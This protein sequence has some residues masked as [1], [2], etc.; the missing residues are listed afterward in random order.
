MPRTLNSEWKEV[1]GE[2]ADEIHDEYVN[3]LGNLTLIRYNQELG[4]KSFDDKKKIYQ[5]KEGLVISRQMITDQDKWGPDQIVK[6]ENW[7]ASK[8]VQDIIPI[9]DSMKKHSNY[10]SG[11]KRLFSF[12]EAGLVGKTIAFIED[13]KI[14]AKVVSNREVEYEGQNWKLSKLTQELKERNGSIS[15]SRSYRGANFWQYD[16]TKLIDL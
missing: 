10:T 1:L 7:I 12:E 13:P 9:P 4:N 5:N 6:R 16:G 11:S 14:T 2:N 15:A 3:R 8:I